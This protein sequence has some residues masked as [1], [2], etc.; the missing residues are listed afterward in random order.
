MS[1]PSLDQF[2]PGILLGVLVALAALRMHAL[3]RSGAWAAAICGGVI[4]SLGGWS[5][6]TI[7]LVF[8]VSSSALSR[9]FAGR[10]VQVNEKFA[11]GSQRDWGQ[12]LANGGLGTVLVIGFALRPDYLWLWIA[13]A[14][15]MAAV[16]AD[17]WATELGILSTRPPRLVTTGKNVGA[18]ESGGVSVLGSLAALGGA[19]VIAMTAALVSE[20][21]WSLILVVTL[22]GLAGSFVDS[23]LGATYQAIYFCPTCSKETE[24]HPI[25]HCG[26]ATTWQHGWAWLNNDWVNFACAL[27]GALIATGLW[28]LINY[29]QPG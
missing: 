13:Y 11:K 5:W 25:H 19:G 4:F 15:S 21:H 27:S 17:T 26:S 12:V 18:G 28:T 16:N 22:G 3:S 24:R 1:S 29:W 20:I 8:F 10:K 6:A 7:L 2:V 14:G 23:F 9:L